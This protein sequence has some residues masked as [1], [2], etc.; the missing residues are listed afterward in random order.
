MQETVRKR[1]NAIIRY[2]LIGVAMNLV[3]SVVKLI[4]GIAS[5]SH[6]LILDSV[7]GLSDMFSSV[8]SIISS[9]L[10]NRRA[11]KQHPLGYGRLEYVFSLV[12][13]MVIMAICVRSLVDSVGS[14]LHPHEAPTYSAFVIIL[15]CVSMLMKLGYGL[16]LRKKGRDL[17]SV[18]MRMAGIESIGD[19]MISAAILIAILVLRFAGK[20][21]EHYLCIGISLLLLYNGIGMIRECMTKLL[22]TRT[23]P[24]LRKRIIHL[25]TNEE[26][27][28]N[29]SNLI[30]H[31]YGEGIQIGSADIEVDEAL[32]AREISL[33]TQRLIREAEAENVM[34]TSIGVRASNLTDPEAE[35]VWDRIIDLLRSFP[36]VRHAHSPYIDFEAKTI[37]LSLVMDYGD[38]TRERDQIRIRDALCDAFPDMEIDIRF[39]IDY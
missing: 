16:L 15:T 9:A 3:L 4:F 7:N 39:M 26:Q 17:R 32:T 1:N 38:R 31:N 12:I 6:A 37:S 2:N 22:G 19:S 13:T 14:I 11:S 25:L 20:D 29:V 24:E 33:L 35:A 30:L 8:L 34:L 28:L 5:H 18:A 23:D 10:G 27:V 21:I 36:E